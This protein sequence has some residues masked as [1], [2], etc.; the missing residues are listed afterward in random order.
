V[1]GRVA[2]LASVL[3]LSRRCTAKSDSTMDLER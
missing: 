1:M 3:I 2:F